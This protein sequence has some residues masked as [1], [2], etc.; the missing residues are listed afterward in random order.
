MTADPSFF[1]DLDRAGFL[2]DR[3]VDMMQTVFERTG[4][5]YIDTGVS[6]KI[7]DGLVGHVTPCNHI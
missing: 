3:N 6:K 2:V 5:H 1:N 4:K 7:V